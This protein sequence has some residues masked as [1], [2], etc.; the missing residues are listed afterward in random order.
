MKRFR[1]AVYGLIRDDD[2]NGLAENIFDGVIIT[3]IVINVAL[4]I[5]DTFDNFPAWAYSLFRYIEVVSVVIFTIEYTVR[6]W[7]APL[8]YADMRPLRATVKHAFS[9]MSIVDLLA[10][11]PFYLPFV[12]PVDLRVLRMVRLLRL[13]RLLKMNRYTTALSSIASVFRRKAAQLVSSMF[14]VALL[15]VMSSVLMYTVENPVQPEVFRNAFSGLWWAVATFTTVGYGDIYPV[16]AAGR[17]IS[18][19]IALLGIGLVAV[20]TGIISAG[21]VEQMDSHRTIQICPHCGKDVERTV[22]YAE[23]K[24]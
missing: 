24:K 1:L 23:A 9:F 3:L 10:I 20:P 17:V 13:L 14:V 16:T 22:S 4:V 8:K 12:F 21:F 2:E 15:M 6:L 5:L 19:I 18:G 11:L 7:T